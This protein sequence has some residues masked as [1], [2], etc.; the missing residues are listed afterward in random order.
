MAQYDWLHNESVTAFFDPNTMLALVEYR[1]ILSADITA[2]VYKWIFQ[3]VQ[4][5]PLDR[6]RGTIYDFR[7]VT[8]FQRDNSA[9]VFKQSTTLNTTVDTTKHPAALIV[10]NYVQEHAV[11]LTMRITPQEERKRIVHS[12]QEALAFI[13]AWNRKTG[14]I[15]DLDI[16]QLNDWPQPPSVGAGH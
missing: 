11:K 6:G 5:V 10:G 4:Q 7:E 1:G 15:F 14:R 12:Q 3:I 9:A 2:A 8:S 13:N 16:R